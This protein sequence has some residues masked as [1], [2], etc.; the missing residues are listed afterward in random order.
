MLHL[1]SISFKKPCTFVTTHLYFSDTTHDVADLGPVAGSNLG[2]LD[3]RIF[4]LDLKHLLIRNFKNR[5]KTL[6]Y[7]GNLG[8]A[9]GFFIVGFQP[10]SVNLTYD[11]STQLIAG[12]RTLRQKLYIEAMQKGKHLKYPAYADDNDPVPIFMSPT[13]ILLE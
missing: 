10:L 5:L 7:E 1:M 3:T 9:S 8:N 11:E 12:N 13:D 6:D 2:L 4:V